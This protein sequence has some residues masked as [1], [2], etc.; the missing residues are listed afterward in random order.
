[1]NGST[2]GRDTPQ[3]TARDKVL[4][5]AI[6]GGDLKM[7]GMLH[8]KVIRSPHAHARIVRIDADAA[9]ALPGVHL[10]LTGDDTPTRLS[11]VAHKEHRILATGKVRFIGEEVVAVVASD[12]DTARDAIDLIQV[13]YEELPVVVDPDHALMPGSI[14]VHDG[15]GN[16]AHEY[17]IVR[18][19]VDAAFETAAAIYTQT[20]E[21]HSQYPGYL[22][23]MA[24][25]AWVGNNDRLNV[26]TPT[27]TPFLQR[28]RFAEALDRP[29]SSIRVIQATTGGGFGGKT[30]EE[31]NSLICAWVATKTRRPVRFLNS[32]LD[33]FQGARASLPERIWLKMGVDKNGV[34]VAKDVR[35]VAEC[36]AYAGLSPEVLQVSV[37]RSDNMHGTLR[38]VRAHAR[39]VYTN[40]PPR[41]AFR[42]FG[43]PQMTFCVNSH[44]T[45]LADMIGMDPIDLH[46]RNAV[47]AGDVTVHGFEI[48]SSGL[49]D[50]L[51]QVR[52]ETDWDRKRARAKGDGPKRRGIGMGAAIHVSGNR[53][54]GNWD[55]ATIVVRMSEDGRVSV[56]TGEADMGQGAYT[57]L[58]QIC[59]HELSLPLDHVTVMPPDTDVAPYGLGSIASRATII[60]G[61]AAI[62]ASREMALKMTALAAETLGVPAAD[63]QLR[64]GEVVATGA[65]GTGGAKRLSYA[66]LARLHIYRQGGESIQTMASHDPLTVQ[67]NAEQYGNVAPAYSFAAQAVEVEVDVETGKVT[68][69]DTFVSDD[70]GKAL[71]PLAVHGQSC[72]AVAQSIGWTLYEHLQ[73]QNCQLLNGNF[74]DYTMPTADSIPEIRS[75][76]V[77]S[78]DPNGP[79]GAKGASE[80]AI[81]PGAGAI[82][83]AVFDAVGVRINTLPIT[84]EKVLAGLAE[85]NASSRQSTE[86]EH[87]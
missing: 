21:T 27:Q 7:P 31:C 14:E 12:E 40:A 73:Y 49:S 46:L 23:P 87:A 4:G 63:L 17:D 29:V 52:A 5:R 35:I 16:V 1:M 84:P 19:D 6:Y 42:G 33:D 64:D 13:E 53:S 75:G 70:C 39:L 82:A 65:E 57:M 24:T 81:V 11:G 66:E 79:Y 76:I 48:G 10:V 43:G 62:K 69:V 80:T 56:L 67:A 9:R 25:V 60:A 44:L 3:V 18:G 37:M 22:E 34:I 54:M 45:V 30:V 51:K 59:A 20:Y 26:W 85:R 36:G 41:G 2:I 32:R 78:N 8:M 77:E 83:N 58:A 38:N 55:G 74:A 61:S 15:T 68:I 50:C 86:S 47:K 28:M 71:N 72:G